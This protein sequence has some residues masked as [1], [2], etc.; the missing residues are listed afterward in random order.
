MKLTPIDVKQQQFG[1]TFRG[2]DPKEVSAFLD[3]AANQMGEMARELTRLKKKV[4]STERELDLHRDREATLKQAM[5]TAQRAIDEIRQQGEKEAELT[6]ADAELRAEKILLSAHQRVGAVLDDIQ[7]LKRQRMRACEELRG[8]LN[9]HQKM[10]DVHDEHLSKELD[11][12][13]EAKVTVLDRVRAPTPPSAK[14]LD[15]AGNLGG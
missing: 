12:A 9:A 4:T 6:I 15:L 2:F 14:P 5:V 10:L 7:D 8:V 3:L 13:P 11:A 1:R